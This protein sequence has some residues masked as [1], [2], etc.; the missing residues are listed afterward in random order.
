MANSQ[1]KCLEDELE[2]VDISE[3]SA[4]FY[5]SEKQ[6]TAL[7]KLLSSGEAD[8][9]N[10]LKNEGARQFLSREEV[11]SLQ[12]SAVDS[13]LGQIENEEDSEL[14]EDLSVSYWPVKSDVPAPILELGW[15][16]GDTW[17]GIT[18]AEVYTHPPA[19][20]APHIK[21]VI[22]KA[23]QNATKVIAVV[24]DIFTDPDIFLDMYEAATRHM[25]PVYIILN[26]HNLASFIHMVET[27]GINVR[28]TENIRVRVVSGCTFST[29]LLKQVTGALKEKFLL[30][31]CNTVITG[32]YSFTWSDS[33]LDR[34]V[35]TVLTGEITDSFDNE[36]RTLFAASRPLQRYDFVKNF[37]KDP[38]I[39]DIIPSTLTAVPKDRENL[40]SIAQPAPV[41]PVPY[42]N[43]FSSP[44]RFTTNGALQTT[45]VNSSPY[46]NPMGGLQLS[47]SI[48]NIAERKTVVPAIV[49]SNGMDTGFNRTSGGLQDS[50]P[51]TLDTVNVPD[52]SI[53]H[54]LAACRNFEGPSMNFRSA[55]ESHSALSDI[56]KNV[57]RN[58]LSVA[59]TTGGRPSKSLW[60]LSQLSQLSG[61]SG[62]PSIRQNP[63]EPGED[64]VSKSRWSIKD[65]PAMLLMRQRAFPE[66]NRPRDPNL[67]SFQSPNNMAPVRLQGQLVHGVSTT[68]LPRPWTNTSRQLGR[69]PHY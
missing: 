61:C 50:L 19:N 69:L 22:R 16:E 39:A 33:R 48:N 37:N 68:N 3:A 43:G 21:V 8:F 13:Q 64:T 45:D 34:N 58:R 14:D 32:T 20:N 31:D 17:K 65:T 44:Q 51:I 6:R 42:T 29:R 47:K 15:P 36:F 56:L 54:R 53:R 23:I 52:Y 41:V 40:S 11:I 63:L 60:D 1:V 26:L 62:E 27:T 5:Y 55:Q 4:N 66:E 49:K 38:H 9:N 10:F 46:L 7:E 67:L 2:F 12:S 18:R 24:M 57:H 28:F 25:I 59:K 35:V 30:V